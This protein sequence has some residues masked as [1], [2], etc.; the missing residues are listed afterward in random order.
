MADP[1]DRVRAAIAGLPNAIV[2]HEA[3]AELHSIPYVK[4]GL[5]TVTVHSQTTHDFIGVTVHRSHDLQL[6]HISSVQGMPTTTIAR[7]VVDLSATL[8]PKHLTVVVDDLIAA[9]RVSIEVIHEVAST[10]WRR[11]KPGAAALRTLIAEREG[12][13]SNASRLERIGLYLLVEAALPVPEIQYPLP[14]NRRRRFD[15]AYPAA[16]LAIEWDSRR[17]HT[18]TEAFDNDRRRDREAVLHGWR[19]V[20]FTWNDVTDRPGEVISTVRELL[21]GLLT[22]VR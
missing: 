9:K 1:M 6:D 22:S 21:K 11:G 16:H 5:A 12:V 3:A 18:Q 20:R 15:A 19:L 4:R 13:A 8:H 10:V 2:S 7:T 14:W 17:W